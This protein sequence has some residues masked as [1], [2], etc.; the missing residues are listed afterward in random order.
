M[1]NKGSVSANIVTIDGGVSTAH[2]KL[3]LSG[4]QSQA[5]HNSLKG[6]KN[7]S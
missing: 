4:Q 6:L 2:L 5:G 7:G 3:L 1:E